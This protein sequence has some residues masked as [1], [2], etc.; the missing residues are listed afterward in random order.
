LTSG[1]VIIRSVFDP[2]IYPRPHLLDGMDYLNI[3]LCPSDW[4]M[5][6]PT[7]HI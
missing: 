2:K 6:Q 3:R 4:Q 7:S 1:Q 5:L